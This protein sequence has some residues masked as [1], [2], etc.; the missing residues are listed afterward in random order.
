MLNLIENFLDNAND[1]S[2]VGSW[3]NW[4]SEI[5]SLTAPAPDGTLTAYVL[6]DASLSTYVSRFYYVDGSDWLH[7]S[8]DSILFGMYVKPLDGSSSCAMKIHHGINSNS[9]DAWTVLTFSDNGSAAASSIA[10]SNGSYHK[11][12]P[13]A[14]G[15]WLSEITLP[16]SGLSEDITV[17]LWPTAADVVAETGELAV[18][19]PYVTLLSQ[20]LALNPVGLSHQAEANEKKHRT[21]DGSL[22]TYRFGESTSLDFGLNYIDKNTQDQLRRWWQED[23]RLLVVNDEGTLVMSCQIR[24]KGVPVTS[25]VPPFNNLY[26]GKIKLETY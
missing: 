7:G 12:T 8:E 19:Q 16:N 6:K 15:W 2:L 17:T 9:Y 26:A 21:R 25:P 20:R 14:D 22:F 5:S 1:F 10:I 13:A 4:F 18:W 23:A 24:N 11:I 3:Q